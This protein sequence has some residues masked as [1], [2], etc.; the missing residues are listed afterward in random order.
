MSQIDTRGEEVQNCL[1]ILHVNMSN[2]KAASAIMRS[3]VSK[4]LL[5]TFDLK[6]NLLAAS[7]IMKQK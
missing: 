1:K 2:L 4:A 7:A 3:K 5:A 6:K